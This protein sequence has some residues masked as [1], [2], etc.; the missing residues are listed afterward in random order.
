MTIE[1]ALDRL[2]TLLGDRLSRTKADLGGHSR[3]ETHFAPVCPDAVA[4]L[5]TTQEVSALVAICAD[6]RCP[7]IGWGLGPHSK[8][9]PWPSGVG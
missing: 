4:Y 6:E 2:T 5:E 8:G 1:A 3:S 9:M 7:V